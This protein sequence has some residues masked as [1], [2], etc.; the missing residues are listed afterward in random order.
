MFSDTAPGS[1]APKRQLS[2]TVSTSNPNF[3]RVRGLSNLGNTCFFN[4]VMQCLAQTHPLSQILDQYCQKGAVLNVPQVQLPQVTSDR[5][6]ELGQ[7]LEA[8]S[9][10]MSE[11]G[12][13]MMALCAFLKVNI[14]IRYHDFIS[15]LYFYVM[16]KSL[17]TNFK[18]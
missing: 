12:S 9:L 8:M 13:T 16:L 14:H 10:Q 17:V 2:S 4:S 18:I 5:K 1:K 15:I 6:V 7:V 11:A 3:P